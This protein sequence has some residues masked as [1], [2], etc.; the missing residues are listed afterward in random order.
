MK[1]SLKLF[2]G[3]AGLIGGL[4]VLNDSKIQAKIS[5]ILPSFISPSRVLNAEITCS[6][7]S[8]DTAAIT[9]EES[10][11]R[12]LVWEEAMIYLK[13]LA[14]AATTTDRYCRNS[15]IAV[16]ATGR[17]DGSKPRNMCL[18]DREDSREMINNIYAI[19]SNQVESKKCFDLNKNSQ[20]VFSPGGF[21]SSQSKHAF[22]QERRTL[23]EFFQN[24]QIPVVRE[25]GLVVADNFSDIVTGDQIQSP[26]AFPSDVSANTLPNLWASVGW[27]PM[28]AK[29]DGRFHN[30]QP[31]ARGGFVYAEVL[32]STGLIRIK[33][34]NG[35]AMRS[36]IGM[37]VQ[38]LDSFYTFHTHD[39]TEIYYN[40][41]KPSCDKQVEAFAMREGNPL[42][43]TISENDHY[44]IVEFDAGLP[45]IKDNFWMSASPV[46]H[47]LTYF[48]ENTIHALKLSSECSKNPEKSGAVAV[49][50]RTR[51]FDKNNPYYSKTNLCESAKR[52]GYPA[53]SD[54]I[55]RCK[56]YKWQF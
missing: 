50:S 12:D 35:N 56:L 20:D 1:F 54:E 3:S 16:F 5:Q 24:L 17:H 18:M 34:I 46:G 22:S 44:R 15:D 32:G 25:H 8:R 43:K 4:L 23:S 2:A 55:V 40:L 6:R 11:Y 27:I 45:S 13:N 41:K 21:L 14:I 38:K 36:E 52:E 31:S 7:P 9:Q 30:N 19:I 28:Y 37:T 29:E 51:G 48:H 42:L 47:D 33:S 53:D 39:A 49:W 10:E 26:S